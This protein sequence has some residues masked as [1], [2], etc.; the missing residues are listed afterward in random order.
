[1]LIGLLLFGHK[2][3]IDLFSLGKYMFEAFSEDTKQK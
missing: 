1:M 3:S 2:D